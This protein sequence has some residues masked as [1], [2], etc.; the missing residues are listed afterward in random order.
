MDR[1]T[2]NTRNSTYDLSNIRGKT[3]QNIGARKAEYEYGGF[4]GGKWGY[5]DRTGKYIIKPRFDK[6]DPFSN[7]LARVELDDTWGYINKTG[8]FVWKSDN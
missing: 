1:T 7:G 2:K 4:V 8:K 3:S 5:I 6:A